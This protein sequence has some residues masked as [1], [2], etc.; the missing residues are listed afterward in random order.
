MPPARAGW[1]AI[2][3]K[4]QSL[5]LGNGGLLQTRMRAEVQSDPAFRREHPA[6]S[7][8]LASAKWRLRNLWGGG[9]LCGPQADMAD[10]LLFFLPPWGESH[11]WSSWAILNPSHYCKPRWTQDRWLLGSKALRAAMLEVGPLQEAGA[12][13]EILQ[14]PRKA[15]G[16]HERLTLENHRPLAREAHANPGGTLSQ[17]LDLIVAR[18]AGC[19]ESNRSDPSPHHPRQLKSPGAR[20]ARPYPTVRGRLL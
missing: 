4:G 17:S 13:V 5:A 15:T 20:A 14:A 6:L 12:I 16:D 7:G 2:F 1:T 19:G 3:H 10:S 11:C 18:A 9:G 8:A